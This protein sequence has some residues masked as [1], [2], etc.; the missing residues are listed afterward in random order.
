MRLFVA[1][2]GFWRSSTHPWRRADMA[3][4]GKRQREGGGGVEGGSGKRDSAAQQ[5]QQKQ[6]QGASLLGVDERGQEL[7]GMNN[8]SFC[9]LPLTESD[10]DGDAPSSAPR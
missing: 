9:P 7:P 6:Q 5:Q 1:H 4:T 10:V 3:T 8:A 2:G